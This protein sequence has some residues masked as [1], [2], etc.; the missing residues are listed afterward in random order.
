[1]ARSVLGS[2]HGIVMDAA[3][4]ELEATLDEVHSDEDCHR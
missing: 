3:L 2:C 4:E 1:L